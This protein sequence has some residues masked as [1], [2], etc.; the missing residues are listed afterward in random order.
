MYLAILLS[1]LF[2]FS[3]GP[4]DPTDST[5]QALQRLGRALCTTTATYTI[6]HHIMQSI[7]A[8]VFSS[9]ESEEA[10][11]RTEGDVVLFLP[12][13]LRVGEKKELILTSTTL[14]THTI[15]SALRGG[16]AR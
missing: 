4:F 16:D 8:F 5:G 15:N 2:A 12:F 7:G 14:S 1:F 9:G 3:E 10:Y 6:V 13:F 11:T